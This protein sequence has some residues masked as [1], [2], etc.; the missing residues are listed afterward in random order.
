MRM[1][2][3]DLRM[4]VVS[5]SS[6][7]AALALVLLGA[8]H[9]FGQEFTD[10]IGREV[11]VF[12]DLVNPVFPSNV[13]SREASVFNDLINPT[14]PVDAV[15]REVAVMKYTAVVTSNATARALP[16]D[17][18]LVLPDQLAELNMPPPQF[19]P[20]LWMPVHRKNVNMA[21]P[22]ECDE[23][24]NPLAEGFV[25]SEA[26]LLNIDEV[27][28]DNC[29][30]TWYRFTFVLPLDVSNASMLGLA[31]VTQ[32]GVAYVNGVQ[33]S[34]TM[35]VPPCVPQPDPEDPCYAAQDTGNDGVDSFG[36]PILTSPTPDV[37]EAS[38]AELF[39]P[40]MNEVVFGVAGDASFFDPTGLEFQAFLFY[41]AAARCPG[42][43]DGDDDVDLLDFGQFQLCYT[44]VDVPFSPECAFAD[45]DGDGDVDLLDFAEFQVQFGQACP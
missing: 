3:N 39:I 33:V 7:L 24:P 20:E 27:T 43:I 11:S 15:S 12:N 9:S 13:V 32:Q 45:L 38:D 4:L 23:S 29:G 28:L 31:N 30:S 5:G 2:L 41:N 22:F 37:F 17:P 25:F 8:P 10:A 36:V 14:E 6:G 21:S 18:D 19:D 40:G 35:N 26:Y 42:D 16:L 34:G 44:G 1:L